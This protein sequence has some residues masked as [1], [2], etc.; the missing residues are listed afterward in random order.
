[1]I[2]KGIGFKRVPVE[3]YEDQVEDLLAQNP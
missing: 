2:E 3:V 1:M